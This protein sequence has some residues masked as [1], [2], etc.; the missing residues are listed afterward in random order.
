MVS[1]LSVENRSESPKQ[2]RGIRLKL[3]PEFIMRKKPTDLRLTWL[4]LID[5]DIAGR[6]YASQAGFGRD[7]L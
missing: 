6:R 7:S 3:Y 2:M 4:G 1:M 5:S